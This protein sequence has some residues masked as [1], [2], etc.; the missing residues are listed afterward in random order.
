M[1]G[2]LSAERLIFSKLL[3]IAIKFV[4]P[5]RLLLMKNLPQLHL[6]ESLYFSYSRL[7]LM[8]RQIGVNLIPSNLSL[9]GLGGSSTSF[10]MST[11]FAT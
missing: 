9:E 1:F 7:L 4:C 6:H 2:L 11:Q 10:T 8:K 3:I 5:S